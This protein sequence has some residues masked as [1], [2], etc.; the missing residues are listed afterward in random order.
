MTR[1]PTP[2]SPHKDT[3]EVLLEQRLLIHQLFQGKFTREPSPHHVPRLPRRGSYGADKACGLPS[4]SAEAGGETENSTW[5]LTVVCFIRIS[6]P[7]CPAH[8]AFSA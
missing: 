6:Q 1:D 8:P 5:S 7:A 2:R 3:G 4:N